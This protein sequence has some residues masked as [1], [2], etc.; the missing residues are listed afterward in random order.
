MKYIHQTNDVID[1]PPRALPKAWGRTS[2][3]D[4]ASTAELKALG[5]LPVVLVDPAFDGTTQVRTGPVG[6][7]MGDAVTANA[8]N[9]TVTYSVRDKTAQEIDDEKDEQAGE[10][11]KTLKVLVLAL[12][13]GS[14]F[15]GSVY[16][17]AQLKAIIKAKL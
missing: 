16:S 14:F 9:V 5:W 2:G 17:D 8:D 13:D 12:N 15:P 3:L 7:Q 1:V 11:L 6:G 10:Q 4:H